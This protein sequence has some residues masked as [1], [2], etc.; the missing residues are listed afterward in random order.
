MTINEHLK[1]F[2]N[3][4]NNIEVLPKKEINLTN[5][6]KEQLKSD[7]KYFL[8]NLEDNIIYRSDYKSLLITLKNLQFYQYI[9]ENEVLENE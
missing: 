9:N 6:Q 1:Q 8:E 5:E 2:E 4:Y 7:L 3:I